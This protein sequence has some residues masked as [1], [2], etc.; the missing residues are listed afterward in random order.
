MNLVLGQRILEFYQKK[1]REFSKAILISLSCGFEQVLTK[2]VYVCF[3]GH[4]RQFRYFK[5]LTSLTQGDE[6]NRTR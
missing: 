1:I 3:Q 6:E 4:G 5:N 2:I